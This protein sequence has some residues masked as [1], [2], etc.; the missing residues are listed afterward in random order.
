[1]I[2]TE[3]QVGAAFLKGFLNLEL[4]ILILILTLP[5]QINNSNQT[6]KEKLELME[7]EWFIHN[8]NKM[9]V[10]SAP[11]GNCKRHTFPTEPLFLLYGYRRDQTKLTDIES[12]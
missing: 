1:M 6:G 7:I 10:L 2:F 4:G 5:P 9:L 8:H 11:G 12:L 3:V